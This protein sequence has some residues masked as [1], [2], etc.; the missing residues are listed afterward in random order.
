MLIKLLSSLLVAVVAGC[1]ASAGESEPRP[2]EIAPGAYMVRG[3]SGEVDVA[4]GGRVGNAGFIVGERG[5]IAIDTGTSYRHGKA[6]LAA[7]RRV[8]DQPVRL[9]L[10]THARQEFLFGAAAF[11]ERGIPIHMQR[12]AARLMQA[13]C[14]GCLKTL[15]QVLGEDAMHGTSIVKPDAE[16]DDSHELDAIGRP[17]RVLQFGLSSGPG[18]IAVLDE[19]SG[20]LFAGGLLD[21]RRVPDVQDSDLGGWRKA[22][23]ALGQPGV[24]TIVPG[25]GPASDSRLIGTIERYLGQL[26]S[27]LLELLDAGVSLSDVADA[28][29]LP[30]FEDWD[31]YAVIHRRNASIVFLRLEREQLLK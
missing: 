13:R 17:V 28:A 6:L 22:L 20:T 11:R 30:Q 7:I 27:R 8:T 10:I 24:T 2:I 29:A 1:A 4:N 25:H 23:Q 19:R 15:K 21:A 31:Q 26:E 14:E 9:V 16:F 3:A 12:R 18:D 5:V